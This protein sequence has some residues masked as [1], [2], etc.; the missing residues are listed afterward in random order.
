MILLIEEIKVPTAKLAIKNSLLNSEIKIKLRL[1]N[2]SLYVA[3]LTYK[4]YTSKI[5][6][7][8]QLLHERLGL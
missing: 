7:H 5:D 3:F 2:Q 8:H 4:A 1:N 6:N